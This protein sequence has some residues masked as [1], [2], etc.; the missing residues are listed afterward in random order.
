MS[1]QRD[2]WGKI[3]RGAARSA[4]RALRSRRAAPPLFF[5]AP[6]AQFGLVWDIASLS[7]GR[8]GDTMVNLPAGSASCVRRAETCDLVLMASMFEKGLVHL[9]WEGDCGIECMKVTRPLAI[10]G[11][12][13]TPSPYRRSKFGTNRHTPAC[14]AAL[15]ASGLHPLDS[16]VWRFLKDGR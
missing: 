16:P 1:R 15:P 5:L 8:A 2:C 14:P 13:V 12:R 3:L 6:A 4:P 7:P 9:Y 10:L 11:A